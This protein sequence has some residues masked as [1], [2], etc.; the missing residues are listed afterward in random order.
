MLVLSRRPG[1][2]FVLP[3]L[4]LTVT[5]LTA[6]GGSVRLGIEAP[7]RVKV[8]REELLA[9]DLVAAGTATSQ[10]PRVRGR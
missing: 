4:G 10:R 7:P 5:V 9:R 2:K 3:D 8:V 1:Q 6:R